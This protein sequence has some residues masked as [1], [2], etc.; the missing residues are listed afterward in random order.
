MIQLNQSSGSPYDYATYLLNVFV[1]SGAGLV[2]LTFED[3]SDGIIYIHSGLGKSE[4]SFGATIAKAPYQKVY[5]TN[6]DTSG[7][8]NRAFFDCFAS[9]A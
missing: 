9:T 4:T 3:W 1:V 6:T 5:W 7:R 2:F 8:C